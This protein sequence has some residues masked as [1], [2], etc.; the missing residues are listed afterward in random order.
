MKKAILGVI[1]S[2]AILFGVASVS[3]T[4]QSGEQMGAQDQSQAMEQNPLQ[5]Q[6]YQLKKGEVHKGA[7]YI[8]G[9]S[10]TVAGEV[11][12]SIYCASEA[13]VVISGI[14]HGDVLC[15]SANSVTI[16]G[17]V[18]QDVRIAAAGD[19]TINGV[20]RGDASLA[21][22]DAVSISEKAILTGDSQV[23]AGTAILNGMFGRNVYTSATNTEI[24]A[25]AVFMGNLEYSGISQA[26]VEDGQ[27]KGEVIFDQAEHES[28]KVVSTLVILLMLLVFGLGFALVAPRYMEHSSEIARKRFGVTIL[29]GVGVVFLTPLIA[30]IL[31]ITVVGIPLSLTVMALYVAAMFASVVFFAYFLGSLLLSNVKNVLLR[32]IG[33][34]VFLVA[35]YIIPIINIIAVIAT[36][37]VGVGIAVRSATH[38]YRSPRYSLT[39]PAP[40]PPLPT[41][42]TQKTEKEDTIEEDGTGKSNNVTKETASKKTIAKKPVTKKTTK[43]T[44]KDKES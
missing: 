14:V 28:S 26:D 41:A 19:I 8:T 25:S 5:R 1:V 4:A 33:G 43:T 20:V 13:P 31:F 10:I 6:G 7:L 2:A 27:V 39:P 42:L 15:A 16:T 40:M 38:N 24:G 36:V 35:L 30:L 12:G 29:A 32:M 17:E 18:K 21:S 22:Q 23:Y 34:V 11:E 9:G 44:S 3:V 37:I